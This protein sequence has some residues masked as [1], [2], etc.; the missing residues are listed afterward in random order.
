M[1]HERQ[2]I[3]FIKM[4]IARKKEGRKEER[5]KGEKMKEKGDLSS[6]EKHIN[7]SL[8]LCN[9]K[10]LA[11]TDEVTPIIILSEE[12]NRSISENTV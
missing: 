5:K 2:M 8:Y 7:I 4:G 11:T 12:M 9:L 6:S 3:D 1:E 10:S